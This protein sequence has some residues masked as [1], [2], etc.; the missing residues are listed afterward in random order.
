MK[1]QQ[2]SGFERRIQRPLRSG[3]ALGLLGVALALAGCTRSTS[4]EEPRYPEKRRPPALRSASDG[5]VMGAHGQAP[6]DT[7]EGSPTNLH[8]AHGWEG[9]KGAAE[10][11]READCDPEAPGATAA[12]EANASEANGRPRSKKKKPCR[13][14]APR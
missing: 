1:T 7:L 2:R 13:E 10:R 12:T 11:A 8:A 6:E 3:T 9:E 5:E 14:P 4:N